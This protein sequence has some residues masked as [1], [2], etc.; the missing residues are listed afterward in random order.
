MRIL[1]K[2]YPRLSDA[3]VA[4]AGHRL[5]V[6]LVTVLALGWTAIGIATAFP[7]WWFVQ[8][9]MAGTLGAVL[10]LLLVQHSQNRDMQALQVK[11][12]ELIRASGAGTHLI[13]LERRE[14]QEAVALVKR[15]DPQAS[16]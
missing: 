4:L 1:H 8:A 6:V 2:H 9:N 12:D 7:R 14:Q 16:A 15:R 10:I 11:V 3:A 5:A 13:G